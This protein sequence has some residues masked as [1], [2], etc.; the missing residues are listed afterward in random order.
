MNKKNKP[1]QIKTIKRRIEEGEK[2][3]EGRLIARLREGKVRLAT[4][5]SKK[6][7]FQKQRDL[8]IKIFKICY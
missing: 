1:V 2:E 8:L 6:T 4:V 5:I 7:A 3:G